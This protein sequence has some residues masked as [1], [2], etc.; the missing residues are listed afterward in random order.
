MRAAG[1]TAVG[2]FHYLGLR[3][4]SQPLEAAAEAGIEL[5]LLLSAYGRGGI[6]RFRQESAAEYLR[7]RGAARRGRSRRRRPPLRPRL[8]AR[9]ARGDRPYAAAE[10]LPLHVHADEQPREIEECLAEHG[11][12]PIELL[13]ETGCLGP[14]TTVV[15]ATHADAAS[16]TCSPRRARGS[17][18][19]RRPRRTSAT[20]SS[21]SR[22]SASAGSASASARTRM[23]ASTRWKSCASSRGSRGGRPA[24]RNVISVLDAP[25]LRLRRGRG[26]AWPRP[27]AGRRGRP[28]APS[29]AGVDEDV[30]GA[31]VFGCSADVF[32]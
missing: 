10:S 14:H 1:Y 26:R 12:R 4:R 28:R 11:L 30:L 18:S 21:R 23:S 17:A 6:E 2:E 15:H 22:R 31:L 3:R 9:L 24:E 25:L 8:P 19:A 27:L 32:V 7:S 29:L 16:S 13:A 5:V 20:A